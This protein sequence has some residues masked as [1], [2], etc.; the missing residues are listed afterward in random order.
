[1]EFSRHDE[2]VKDQKFEVAVDQA[3]EKSLESVVNHDTKLLAISSDESHFA[4]HDLH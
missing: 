2:G 4:Y 3:A 1:V